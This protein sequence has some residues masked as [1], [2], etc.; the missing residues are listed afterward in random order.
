[1]DTRLAR[2]LLSE[3]TIQHSHNLSVSGGIDK[4]NYFFSFG[5]A[6]Q[7]NCVLSNSLRRFSFRANIDQKV[8]KLAY[9]WIQRVV[10][11]AKTTRAR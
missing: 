9:C 5:Y 7:E 3:R 11:P 1:M 2:H 8:N 6:D 4:T 10:L